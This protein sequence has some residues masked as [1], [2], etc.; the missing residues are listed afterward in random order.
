MT[1][2]TL[3]GMV[4]RSKIPTRLS[5]C[6]STFAIRRGT[7]IAKLD[8][9]SQQLQ[10]ATTKRTYKAKRGNRIIAT[11]FWTRFL[12]SRSPGKSQDSRSPNTKHRHY[13]LLQRG[14]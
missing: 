14:Q 10:T 5:H 9:P 12:P 4:N 6:V 8:A 7:P 1:K 3:R 2:N 13:P 11:H